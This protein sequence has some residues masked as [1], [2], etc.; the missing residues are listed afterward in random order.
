M[1]RQFVKTDKKSFQRLLNRINGMRIKNDQTTL[2]ETISSAGTAVN[3][4]Q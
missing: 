4:F 3:V 2:W 1:E